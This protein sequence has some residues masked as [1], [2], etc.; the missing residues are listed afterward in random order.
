MTYRGPQVLLGVGAVLATA[1]AL[2]LPFPARGEELR[3]FLL[4]IAFILISIVAIVCLSIRPSMGR[5]LALLLGAA[6]AL[7]LLLL[8]IRVFSGT[9]IG[10]VLSAVIGSVPWLASLLAV[11]FIARHERRPPI[12]AADA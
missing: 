9:I 2:F 3:V 6:S 1:M 7:Q 8:A 12:R 10:G 4:L 5:T 11:A